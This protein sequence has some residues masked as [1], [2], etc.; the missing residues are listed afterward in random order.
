M[1][2][3]DSICDKIILGLLACNLIVLSTPQT[4]LASSS[5]SVQQVFC[6]CRYIVIDQIQLGKCYSCYRLQL[7]QLCTDMRAKT[8]QEMSI[9]QIWVEEATMHLALK[10]LEKGGYIE[11]FWSDEESGGG[12]RKYYRILPKRSEK[13]R[14]KQREREFMK[15]ILDTFYGGEKKNET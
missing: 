3:H 12:R 9:K 6:S 1:I 5:P 11:S 8:V 14:E 4:A 15:S 7:L 13:Y 2:V 10:R